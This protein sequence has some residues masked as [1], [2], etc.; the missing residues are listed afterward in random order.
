[1]DPIV[2]SRIHVMYLYNTKYKEDT[3]PLKAHHLECAERDYSAMRSAFKENSNFFMFTDEAF[4]RSAFVSPA[5]I[6][7]DKELSNTA[8]IVLTTV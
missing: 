6:S 2:E 8:G 1:M 4:V 7:K 3:N 5:F